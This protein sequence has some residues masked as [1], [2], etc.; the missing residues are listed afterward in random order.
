MSVQLEDV[1]FFSWMSSIV[2]SPPVAWAVPSPHVEWEH[3]LAA[4]HIRCGHKLRC[5]R[6]G[7]EDNASLSIVD[8]GGWN[9]FP[10]LVC[11][12][13]HGSH[14]WS[15]GLHGSEDGQSPECHGAPLLVI[16]GILREG[17]CGV[18]GSRGTS[19]R[20]KV[21]ESPSESGMWVGRVGRVS[22]RCRWIW[23]RRVARQSMGPA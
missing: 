19:S 21:T 23:G 17:C 1:P 11:P 8:T 7:S 4:S 22:G 6:R 16:V 10:V 9:N 2:S 14:A 5:S 20:P 15:Q 13:I 12:S 18:H 3:R